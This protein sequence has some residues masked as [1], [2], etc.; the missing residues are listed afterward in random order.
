MSSFGILLEHNEERLARPVANPY[1]LTELEKNVAA[2]FGSGKDDAS[3][4][5]KLGI[6][7]HHVEAHLQAISEK[8]SARNRMHL[9]LI[10][11]TLTGLPVEQPKIVAIEDFRLAFGMG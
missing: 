3:I 7:A 5:F 6:E 10:I 8:L 1:H 9:S 4:A 2:W 11:N